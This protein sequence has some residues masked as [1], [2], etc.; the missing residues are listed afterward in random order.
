M[1][2][3]VFIDIVNHCNG[4]CPYCLTG[5]ANRQGLNVGR[6][7]EYMD[8]KAFAGVVEHLLDNHIVREGPWVGLYN[9]Y[10]PFLNPEL[11]R[12]IDYAADAGLAL[13][14]STNA[15]ECPEIERTRTC[16]HVD[17]VVFSMPGFSQRSYDRVHGFELERVTGNIRRTMEALRDRGFHRNAYIHFHVYQWNISE[18]HTAKR[19]ADE[20]GIGI[21]FT[22]AY[23]NNSEFRDYLE[24][25]MTAE[26]LKEVSGD[27]FFCYLDDLFDNLERYREEFAEPP[28]I[29][30][31]E[32]GNLLVDRNHNDQG[33]LASVFDFHSYE[34]VREFLETSVRPDEIDE[35]IAVWGRTF[36]YTINHLFGY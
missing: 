9:W 1:Y 6:K 10:E 32:R 11:P 30:L 20:L 16:G 18:V 14:V 2:E 25:T 12:I 31:S 15:S 5:G 22:Y 26:R 13:G 34:E 28:T 27:L 17:E 21:K 8:V 24:G 29:V 19:F 35:K 3:D 4:M 7:K 23:F 36:N 33:A